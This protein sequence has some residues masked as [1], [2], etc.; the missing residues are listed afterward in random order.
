[1]NS[2]F[3]SDNHYEVLGLKSNCNEFDVRRAYK[4]MAK[5]YHPDKCK[6]E[7]TDSDKAFWRIKEAYDVLADPDAKQEFDNYEKLNQ[8]YNLFVEGNQHIY[9]SETLDKAFNELIKGDY[10]TIKA[11]RKDLDSGAEEIRWERRN[12]T[13][14]PQTTENRK[15][16]ISM[17][18]EGKQQKFRI[19][20][21]RS[22]VYLD[23]HKHK[24][25]KTEHIISKIQLV[26]SKD[27]E[28]AKNGDSKFWWQNNKEASN[29][30]SNYMNN[31]L[32]LKSAESYVKEQMWE[33]IWKIDVQPGEKMKI[34]TKKVEGLDGKMNIKQKIT[35]I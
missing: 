33:N 24:I 26:D 5:E 31:D 6:S 25:T 27:C 10:P 13:S 15:K 4:K 2:H 16:I 20:N 28:K 7:L 12:S 23:D 35:L 19:E 22:M 17:M 9:D 18:I 14:G 21:F 1:M 8:N 29:S 3:D 11:R 30:D 32:Y 34:L